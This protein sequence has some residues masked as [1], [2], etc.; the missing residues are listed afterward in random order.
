MSDPVVGGVSAGDEFALSLCFPHD[1]GLATFS[2]IASETGFVAPGDL[3]AASALNG[4]EELVHLND[5]GRE[6]WPPRS[7]CRA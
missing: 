6:R 3:T 7:I 4:A 2:L 5:E 1:T